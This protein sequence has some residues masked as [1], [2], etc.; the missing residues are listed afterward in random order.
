[1]RGKDCLYLHQNDPVTKKP[2]AADP[3]DVQRL[4]GRPQIVPKAASVPTG[5][6]PPAQS[7]T[8]PI[9]TPTAVPK[10]VVSMIRVNRRDLEPESEPGT[11]H[12]VARWRMVDGATVSNHPIGSVPEPQGGM[13]TSP[14]MGGL[15]ARRTH[16]GSNQSSMWCQCHLCGVKTPTVTYKDVCCATC[17]RLP[18]R[19]EKSWTIMKNCV[20][21]K[22]ARITM[23]FLW[24][25]KDRE[26]AVMHG[27]VTRMR[28]A[29][30][31]RNN[32]F[33]AAETVAQ[34]LE[35]GDIHPD[36]D[37]HWFHAPN[38]DEEQSERCNQY[39]KDHYLRE[40]YFANRR[41]NRRAQA[42]LEQRVRRYMDLRLTTIPDEDLPLWE[43][44]Y[45]RELEALQELQATSSFQA[46]DEQTRTPL[47]VARGTRYSATG[48]SRRRTRMERTGEP[49]ETENTGP[50]IS[51]INVGAL[52]AP[53]SEDDRYCMLDSGANVMVIPKMEGM[54]GD[55]TMCSLVGDNRATGLIVSR[56]YIGTKLYLVVAVQ[57]ATVL[58][59]P[60]YLV[61]I[62]G[63]RLSW[64]NQS[65]GEIFHLK[66]GYGESVAVHEDDDLLYLNK[67]TF[68]RV[69]K[70]M[71]NAA[72]NRTG[73]DWPSIWQALT[74][75]R[76]EDVE[77]NAI[78]SVE[79][80]TQ[81]DFMELFNPGNFKAQK[82]NLNAGRTYDVKVDPAIDLTRT[83]V[84]EQVR[85]SIAQED[86]MI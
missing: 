46:T 13:C 81:V 18:P 31:A 7:S 16:F 14:H 8:T 36:R 37:R 15:H 11:R 67:N 76:V 6:P 83:S 22:W 75:K 35:V 84:Q 57:N 47:R 66:D 19:R 58:L 42:E 1:M 55:E 52:R 5:P 61:R 33:D 63:Y 3:A 62:A 68:W 23:K 85:L 65:G 28:N 27:A 45:Q 54:V 77:I 21:A 78:R 9:N 74:G 59:P 17:Y 86:P 43:E 49:V 10:P 60:A 4:N 72:Q 48:T 34:M 40:I 38:V 41:V 69:A 71:F 24:L 20:W 79:P 82:G 51:T 2:L 50:S 44:A 73:M 64:A 70:D 80:S 32:F 26:N 12:R 29:R 30:D 56:L 25:G 39:V 53:T